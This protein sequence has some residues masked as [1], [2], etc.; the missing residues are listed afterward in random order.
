MTTSSSLSPAAGHWRT[1]KKKVYILANSDSTQTLKACIRT[2]MSQNLKRLLC[3]NIGAN[4]KSFYKK[5]K[6]LKKFGKMKWI[7]KSDRKEKL[8]EMH[9]KKPDFFHLKIIFYCRKL[10]AENLPIKVKV[11]KRL[12][13]GGLLILQYLQH[14]YCA[15]TAK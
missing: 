6:R 9:F 12:S 2:E 14:T 10:L 1:L 11:T 7:P 5:I 8:S 3:D 13:W 15:K 4:E